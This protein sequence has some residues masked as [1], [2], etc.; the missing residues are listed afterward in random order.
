MKNRLWEPSPPF[1]RLMLGA[2]TIH[3]WGHLA[4]ESGWVMIPEE[5]AEERKALTGK[6]ADL[7]NQVPQSAS[8]A[9]QRL[10]NPE[11]QRLTQ[12][13]GSFGQGLLAAMLR[14]IEDYM[15][16]LVARQFLSADEMDTY[17]R[18]NVASR[19]TEYAPEKIYLQLIRLVY[20]YQYL[21]LSRIQSPLKWF[22]DS[23][24]VDPLFVARGAITRQ[25]FDEILETVSGICDC[26]QVDDS[27]FDFDRVPRQ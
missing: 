16:N 25:Q 1:E 7:F 9:I 15:A 4:A 18:N 19:V 12:K 3:E 23:T 10:V 21:S 2:R 6:L 27:Q 13:H 17:V 20:E 22:C 5:R 11:A 8:P 24:W 26:Y 14:R